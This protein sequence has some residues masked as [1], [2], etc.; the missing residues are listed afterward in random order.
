MPIAAATQAVLDLLCIIHIYK[1]GRPYYWYFIVVGFPVLG[2]LAYFLFEVIPSTDGRRLAK[3]VIRTIDLSADLKER[4]REVE[5]CGSVANRTALAEELINTG[6]FD[7][8]SK[9]YQSCLQ[10]LHGD[11][12]GIL[13]GIATA[14]F[15]KRDAENAL[16]W[17]DRLIAIEPWFSSGDAKLMRAQALAGAGRSQEAL[18]QYEAI[19]DHYAGEEARCRYAMLLTQQ[20]QME[21]AERVMKDVDKRCSLNGRQYFRSNQE[22][23]GEARKTIK[24]ARDGR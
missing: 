15:H 6:Q 13:F 16:H 18:A 2:A 1:T 22:W 4:V 7:E 9:L 19:L 14:H 3:R 5:R 23:I 17:L 21:A 12:P 24:D 8:A 11:D 10:G 20:G